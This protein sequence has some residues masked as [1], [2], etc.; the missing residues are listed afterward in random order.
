MNI[1]P[2]VERNSKLGRMALWGMRQGVNKLCSQGLL[3]FGSSDCTYS[4]LLKG[5]FHVVTIDRSCVPETFATFRARCLIGIEVASGLALGSQKDNSQ[6]QIV[7]MIP[8]QTDKRQSALCRAKVRPP[9]KDIT[10]T[11][12]SLRQQDTAVI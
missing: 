5:P 12:L 2:L 7:S 1:I 11:V 6:Q 8:V 3:P 4:E 10:G 9:P